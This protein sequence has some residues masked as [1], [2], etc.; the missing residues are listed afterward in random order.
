MA[1]TAPTTS[2]DSNTVTEDTAPNPISGN[3]L[4]ND[5]DPDGDILAVANWGTITL[6]YGSLEIHA[7]GSYTYTLDNSNPAVDALNTGQHLTDTFTYTASDG[8]GGTTSSTLTITINGST[9]NRPP[10]VDADTNTIREDAT[11]ITVSGN[12]LSNDSD[13][14][15]HTLSVANAGTITLQ[16]GSLEIHADGSYTYTL[17]NSNP[18]VDALNTGQHL[19]DT[20]IYVASDGH[21]G[22]TS[23]TLTVI[24]D[25]STDNR[26]P[27]VSAD[28]NTIREDA[29]PNTVSGNVLSN[30][31]DADGN[32]LS[33]ANAGTISLQYGSLEIHG[34]GSYTYTLDNSNPAVDALNTGQHL[35]DTFTY[36]ASDGHGGTTSSTLTVTIDGTT[37]NRPPVVVGDTNTILEDATPNTV[38]GNVL[39]NDSDPD[40]H[41]LSIA[42]AG[43]ITLQYGSLEIHADGSYA[44]QLQSGCRCPQHR[45]ASHRHLHIYGKRRAWRHDQRDL[46]H[47]HQWLD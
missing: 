19:T 36:V 42:N 43:T 6:Q 24:I 37:D 40:G 11:P 32:T 45:A 5:S 23:S 26:P 47:H 15:G 2:V 10:V 9:D 12:V 30:D 7:D 38:S 46:D 21:G 3:V 13:P 41:T 18:A 35:T 25:G 39:A 44:R 14:D 29:T 22:T 17:D 28:T 1:N 4:T 31:S 20:F 34:D 16:Y 33:V 27:V 8:N